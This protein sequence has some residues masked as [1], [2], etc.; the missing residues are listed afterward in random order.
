MEKGY[1]PYSEF[2]QDEEIATFIAANSILARMTPSILLN[3]FGNKCIIELKRSL[4]DI[5]DHT[6]DLATRRK[7]MESLI[8][9][10]FTAID[11][12]GVNT[13][14]YKDIF[15]P[16]SDNAFNSY[17]RD[18]FA[19]EDKYLILTI[20]D[21][22]RTIKIPDIERAAKVLN[23]PLYE[24][25]YMP[26]INHDKERPV[27]TIRPVPVGY[28]N[29]KRTQQTIA[30]KNGLS[31]NIDARSAITGQVVQHDKN[32][33]ESDLENIMLT[34]LGLTNTLKELNGPRA[35]DLVMKQQMNQSINTKGYVSLSD[36]DDRIENKT[37]L[38]TVDTYFLGMGL[39]TDLVTKG[40]KTISTIRKE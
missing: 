4:K 5:W 26:H 30:K 22:E 19:N 23:I 18:F 7:N 32:G 36:L 12:S 10:F 11:K 33:R 3:A 38:N 27:V 34:S 17:F 35:D 16:M 15:E 6:K 39:K 8:Y 37:T 21:Y 9:K 14:H 40:L 25:V 1:E 28:I 31:T 29:I 13:K 20:V 2:R 24:Y